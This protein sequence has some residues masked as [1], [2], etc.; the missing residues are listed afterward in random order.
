MCFLYMSLILFSKALGDTPGLQQQ[1]AGARPFLPAGQPVFS[2]QLHP[3]QHVELDMGIG[4][5]VFYDPGHQEA[6]FVLVEI[7]D[8]P[9]RDFTAEVFFGRC[10]GQHDGV[11]FSE[12]RSGVSG[13]KGE[14]EHA[15]ETGIGKADAVLL[16]AALTPCDQGRLPGPDPGKFLDLGVGSFQLGRQG[17]GGSG[18]EPAVIYPVQDSEDPVLL[19]M[20]MIETQSRFSPRARGG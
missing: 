10:L 2:E 3:G 9:Q 11:L 20:E 7:Q 19:D 4:G 14:G 5:D 13:D 16:E 18:E 8:L 12:R 17:I 15:E 1:V 6:G